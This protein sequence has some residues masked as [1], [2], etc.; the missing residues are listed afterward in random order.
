MRLRYE[1][2]IVIVCALL[3]A[4]YALVATV[5]TVTVT[6]NVHGHPV[7]SV[8][9]QQSVPGLVLT[10]VLHAAG[11]AVLGVAIA[12]LARLIHFLAGNV[13]SRRRSRPA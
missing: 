11:G 3:A 7:T 5:G 6:T 8:L 13:L 1:H 2:G 9:Y 12:A 10:V 4:A